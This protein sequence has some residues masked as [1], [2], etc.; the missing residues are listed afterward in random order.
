MRTALK[1]VII[2]VVT[3]MLAFL[4]LQLVIMWN[5]KRTQESNM[6]YLPTCRFFDINNEAVYLNSLNDKPIMLIVFDPDCEH[7]LY[8]VREIKKHMIDLIKARLIMISTAH[9]PD[10]KRFIMNEGLDT[11]PEIIALRCDPGVFNE[12][13]GNTPVPS[14]FIYNR[15]K[16]LQSVFKG[17]VNIVV[18]INVLNKSLEE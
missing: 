8:E 12:T 6:V 1:I 2:L 11:I 14:V 16:K 17:E 3:S 7:C 18:L 15:D 10:I 5:K 9:E 4:S 13:F